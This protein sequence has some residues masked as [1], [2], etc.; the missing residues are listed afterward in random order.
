MITRRNIFPSILAVTT[1]GAIANATGK[2]PECNC[3]CKDGKDGKDGKPGP[4][5]PKGEKGEKGDPG[6]CECKH[7]IRSIHVDFELRALGIP[8]PVP[9]I[10]AN[11]PNDG[12]TGLMD[13]LWYF[14]SHKACVFF[15]YSKPEPEYIVFYRG[16]EFPV[17]DRVHGIGHRVWNWIV[18]NP[19]TGCAHA[20]IVSLDKILAKPERIIQN[21]T[22][23]PTTYGSF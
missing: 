4:P 5:G 1:T 22:K 3:K 20:C 16:G 7:V 17:W 15:D 9:D 10:I 19:Q 2:T 14:K 21:W 11:T 8:I 18:Q 12:K 6:E 13:E 23:I